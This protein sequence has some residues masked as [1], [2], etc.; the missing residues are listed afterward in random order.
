MTS[1][2]VVTQFWLVAGWNKVIIPNQRNADCGDSRL[3]ESG[4]APLVF[5]RK[6]GGQVTFPRHESHGEWS[7]SC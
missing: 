5:C 2:N 4:N 7:T 1:Q 6:A 3:A